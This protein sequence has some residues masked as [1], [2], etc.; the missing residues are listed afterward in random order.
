[1]SENASSFS[2]TQPIFVL[3]RPAGSDQDWQDLDRGP[4][5]FNVPEGHEVRV[6]IKS[7]DDQDLHELVK[8]L[9]DVDSLRFLDLAE[10]RNVTNSGL[11]RLKGLPQ[12]TGLNISSCTVTD[13]GIE[14]LRELPRL[15]HLNVSYCNRLT[16]AALKSFEAMRHLTYVDIQGC[17][18]ITKGG[19]ARV[20][21]RNLTLYRK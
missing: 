10:N 2:S 6:R 18:S 20:R 16:D 8:E 5:Y 12:L 19:L 1:M 21:R 9:Q 7:I 14:Q 15:A 11:M 17:L 4:G 13:S 3:T